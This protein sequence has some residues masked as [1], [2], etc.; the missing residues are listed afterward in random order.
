[1]STET[2]TEKIRTNKGERFKAR[3]FVYITYKAYRV[4]KMAKA[5]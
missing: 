2:V 1:M 3:V 5:K 4:A